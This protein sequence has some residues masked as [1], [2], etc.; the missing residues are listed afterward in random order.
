[1]SLEEHSNLDGLCQLLCM[2]CTFTFIISYISGDDLDR[3]WS[4]ASLKNESSNVIS[5]RG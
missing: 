4:A 2:L 3:P 1:M 5:C